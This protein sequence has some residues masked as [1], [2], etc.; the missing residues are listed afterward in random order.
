MP[1]DSPTVRLT[2]PFQPMTY[3]PLSRPGEAEINTYRLKEGGSNEVTAAML[4][5]FFI[6]WRRIQTQGMGKVMPIFITI[7]PICTAGI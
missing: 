3:I 6:T 2:A 4:S 1:V 7:F 5:N